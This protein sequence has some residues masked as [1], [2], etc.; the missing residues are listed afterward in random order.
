MYHD[1]QHGLHLTKLTTIIEP[2]SATTMEMEN[3]TAV[4]AAAGAVQNT[5][6]VLE[7]RASTMENGEGSL[8]PAARDAGR[9]PNLS[10][11]DGAEDG[12]WSQWREQCIQ[13]KYRVR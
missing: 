11:N 7:L 1:S 8:P 6:V 2:S 12:Q 9:A 3:P 13:E 10:P 5:T 4:P